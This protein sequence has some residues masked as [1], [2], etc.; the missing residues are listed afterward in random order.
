[1]DANDTAKSTLQSPKSKGL[2]TAYGGGD[3]G[4]SDKYPLCALK[5]SPSKKWLSTKNCS[6]RCPR[7]DILSPWRQLL[8]LLIPCH[9][10]WQLSYC[11]SRARTGVI[12]RKPCFRG[13][14]GC[15]RGRVCSGRSCMRGA[16]VQRGCTAGVW[17]TTWVRGDCAWSR[18][19][20]SYVGRVPLAAARAREDGV[21]TVAWGA[22]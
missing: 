10:H 4:L 2:R 12:C 9:V 1:V 13:H 17:S 19:W 3:E 5:R 11:Q 18:G 7:P 8:S 21:Q 6:P 20:A 22:G 14:T 15:I 16:Q